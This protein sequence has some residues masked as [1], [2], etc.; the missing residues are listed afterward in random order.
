MSVIILITDSN[1]FILFGYASHTLNLHFHDSSFA[2]YKISNFNIFNKFNKL[3]QI[4]STEPVNLFYA[5][6]DRPIAAY[7]TSSIE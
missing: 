4:L 5:E 3:H 1:L 6:I 7:R 2:H